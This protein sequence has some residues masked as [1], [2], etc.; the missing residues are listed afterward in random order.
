MMSNRHIFAIMAH[1]Q[2]ELTESLIELLAHPRAASVLH[3]N[4]DNLAGVLH[5]H[6]TLDRAHLIPR[7]RVQWGAYSLLT[8]QLRLLR[9]A[10]DAGC[11]YVHLLSG[12]DLP[13]APVSD[14]LD[15]VDSSDGTE[16]IHINPP[17]HTDQV[18]ERVSRYWSAGL[19]RGKV[20]RGPRG[21]ALRVP[22]RGFVTAQGMLGVDRSRQ[23]GRTVHSGSTWFTVTAE[24]AQH[25]V[26][27][28][29]WADQHLRKTF[30]PEE[31][32]YATMAIHSARR[33]HIDPGVSDHFANLRH[34][35]WNPGSRGHPHT[36]RMEDLPELASSPNMFARKFDLTV[37]R[38][39]VDAVVEMASRGP[40]S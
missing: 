34:I 37:D 17:A 5:R 19:L 2:F 6:P 18:I 21:A 23:W 33:S 32:F 7:V 25:F 14:I 10:L 1:D 20:D 36:W 3:L 16:F 35:R 13:L 11:D 28:E 12:K 15:F 24:L 30:V 38:D 8:V 39:V 9:A 40:T 22:Q 31:F 26:D 29:G 4:V 27:H